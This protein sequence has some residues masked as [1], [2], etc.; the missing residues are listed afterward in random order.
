MCQGG[1]HILAGT[2]VLRH[3]LQSAKACAILQFTM[4]NEFSANANIERQY[5][6]HASLGKVLASDGGITPR[7]YLYQGI[8]WLIGIGFMVWFFCIHLPAD[9]RRTVTVEVPF[10]DDVSVPIDVPATLGNADFAFWFG[11]MFVAVC[12]LISLWSISVIAS[13]RIT[14]YERGIIGVSP[15]TMQLFK[16]KVQ[17]SYDKISSV[18]SDWNSIRIVVSGARYRVFVKNPTEI[19]RIIFEQQQKMRG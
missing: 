11:V 8:P 18:D 5:P 12:V 7:D 15:G 1:K 10:S 14:V 13:S 3:L 19:Q 4:T 17:L 9:L 6:E 2:P 16:R